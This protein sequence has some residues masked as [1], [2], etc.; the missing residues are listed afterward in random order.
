MVW[1]R[2]NSYRTSALFVP[3]SNFLFFIF[4]FFLLFQSTRLYIKGIVRG[5]ASKCAWQ[6]MI[7]IRKRVTLVSELHVKSHLERYSNQKQ[8][9][10]MSFV[11]SI[12]KLKT[13]QI[14]FSIQVIESVRHNVHS[15]F[16]STTLVDTK[17]GLSWG[18]Y[19]IVVD[20]EPILGWCLIIEG[21]VFY[22]Q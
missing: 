21:S 1:K 18:Q 15:D 20:V 11:C 16:K 14:N 19:W 8:T 7:S 2:I 9:F 5:S 4:I 10:A 6:I 13:I 12:G 3:I 17:S 22:T